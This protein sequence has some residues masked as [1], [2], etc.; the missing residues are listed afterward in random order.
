M[1]AKPAKPAILISSLL[2]LLIR[3]R[4]RIVCY[5]D[6]RLIYHI[7]YDIRIGK[8]GG[9]PKNTA[10]AVPASLAITSSSQSASQPSGRK[11]GR[12]LGSLNKSTLAKRV[13]KSA[14]ENITH[15]DSQ[16]DIFTQQ[17]TG[18]RSTVLRSGKTTGVRYS[19]R[20][21]QRN[22]RRARSQWEIAQSDEEHASCIIVKQ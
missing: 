19:G 9:R 21:T 7:G 11:R 12:P 4:I 1:S 8:S 22:I 13:Q 5:P 16:I 6:I 17:Q 18:R 3:Y 10:Q 15:T 20:R 2:I 14:H